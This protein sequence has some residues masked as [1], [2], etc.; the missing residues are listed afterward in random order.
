[1]ITTNVLNALSETVF[2]NTQ[3]KSTKNLISLLLEIMMVHTLSRS[4]LIVFTRQAMK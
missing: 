2:I 3:R 1:M 4:R